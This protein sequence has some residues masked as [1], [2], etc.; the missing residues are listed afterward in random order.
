MRAVQLTAYGNPVEGLKYVDIPEPDAPGPNQVLIGVEFSPLN[1]SDLLLARGIYA[2]RPALPTVI[3]NE[4]VG[5][6]LRM[7][8]GVQN[9]KLGDRVLAP[10]SSFTWR[11]RMVIS[12]NGL[13]ALPADADARQLAMLAINPPTAALLLSEYVNLKPGEWVVQN[14]ANSEVG[15]WVI[16]FAKTRGLKTVNIVRRPELVPELEAIGAEG[17]ARPTAGAP[18]RGRG[19]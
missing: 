9:V 12:A 11:E 10:L 3:G 19:D 14:A 5:H 1:P 17:P 18:A 2:L 8:P 16:A 13:F 15:R 7:G 6:V 4:G